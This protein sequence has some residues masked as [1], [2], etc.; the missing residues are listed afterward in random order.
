MS[1]SR[2]PSLSTVLSNASDFTSIGKILA[3]PGR[4]SN[5]KIVPIQSQSLSVHG[6]KNSILWRQR[7]TSR[8]T[9]RT[10][11]LRTR[12]SFE[13]ITSSKPTRMMRTLQ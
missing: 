4:A 1:G 10:S 13:W 8:D 6:V 9:T 3:A 5:K 12:K 2:R 11:H 7:R